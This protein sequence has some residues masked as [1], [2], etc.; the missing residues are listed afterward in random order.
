MNDIDIIV[1]IGLT[2]NRKLKSRRKII[3]EKISNK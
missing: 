2:E 1:I 3:A